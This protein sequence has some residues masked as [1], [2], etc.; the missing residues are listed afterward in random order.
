MMTRAKAVLREGTFPEDD[1][2]GH[3]WPWPLV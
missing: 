3:R 1:T 2:A